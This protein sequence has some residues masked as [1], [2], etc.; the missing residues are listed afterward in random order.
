MREWFEARPPRGACKLSFVNDDD[1]EN[2]V[3]RRGRRPDHL[4]LIT[5]E[6]DDN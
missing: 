1:D 2:T 6:D 5:T 3:P 4:R